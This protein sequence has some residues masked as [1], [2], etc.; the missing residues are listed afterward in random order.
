MGSSRHRCPSPPT[1]PP[2]SPGCGFRV[3]WAQGGLE[4]QGHGSL[5]CSKVIGLH[6]G[7][8]SPL[9]SEVGGQ[10]LGLA[11]GIRAMLVKHASG[12]AF[13]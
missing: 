12:G 4:G 10:S 7:L 1:P 11:V 8:G 5:G 3:F 9:G 6:R 13:L 2:T